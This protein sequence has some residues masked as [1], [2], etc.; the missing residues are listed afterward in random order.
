MR[1]SITTKM[2]LLVSLLV[3]FA[4]IAVGLPF[5]LSGKDILTN[6]TFKDLSRYS[7]LLAEHINRDISA[8]EEDIHF[9]QRTPPIQGIIR[10]HQAGGI[11]PVTR[12]N[13]KQWHRSLE[14]IF[15]E[16]LRAKSSYVQLMYID[17]ENGG[18]EIVRVDRINNEISLAS[19]GNT[20]LPDYIQR[21]TDLKADQLYFSK[22]E[23]NRDQGQITKPYLPVLHVATPVYNSS[24]A[25]FGIIVITQSI[26]PLLRAI[27]QNNAAEG[28]TYYATNS[29]GDYID[30]PEPAITYGFD[31]GE[32]Y[33]IQYEHPRLTE[34]FNPGNKQSKITIIDDA[35]PVP[36][37]I[38][39]KK[40][41]YDTLNPDTYIAVGSEYSYE[42]VTNTVNSAM[43]RTILF[44]LP[45]LLIAI[46][47]TFIF[48]RLLTRPILKITDAIT[49]FST[50]NGSTTDL[51]LN[52]KDEIGFLARSIE[53]MMLT[54]KQRTDELENNRATLDAIF[55][56]VNEAVITID[57]QGLIETVNTA[58]QKLFGYSEQELTGNNIS[59]LMPEPYRSDHDNYIQKYLT[60]NIP[61]IIGTG[62]E[63]IAQNRDGAIFPIELS[64]SEHTLSGHKHFT[65]V[66]RDITQRVDDQKKIIAAMI[67]AEQANTAKS[68]FLSVMNHELRTP[69]NGVLGMLSLLNDAPA[70]DEQA[71]FIK[72]AIESA[73]LLLAL[74]NDVIEYTQMDNDLNASEPM[75]FNLK[76][77]LS[78]CIELYTPKAHA[79]GL[80]LS[81]GDDPA[82]PLH[83]FVGDAPRLKKAL[84]CLIDNAIKYTPQGRISL[85]YAYTR[86]EDESYLIRIEV[87]DTGIGIADDSLTKIFD[88]FIQADSSST[89]AYGGTGLGL[90]IAKRLIDSMNGEIGVTSA[91]NTGSCFWFTLTLQTPPQPN[92]T[93]S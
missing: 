15:T 66:I 56:S 64:I 3:I 8:L 67:A 45:L 50:N 17:I 57:N 24:G 60:T 77:L 74:L 9:L 87:H 28:R 4:S 25:V 83:N 51:P 36:E 34:F 46:L 93:D 63:I 80:T 43:N 14:I 2:T 23:L 89:R 73:N 61:A 38:N 11:D 79:R 54:V 88:P 44:S 13:D 71:M 33:L 69:L 84:H 68:E 53:T 41:Y 6:E 1:P 37:V 49:G 26:Q 40:V 42:H 92:T 58:G 27:H 78:G 65:G 59:S 81:I 21:T 85:R 32:R 31:K 86:Q 30:H 22:I 39:L 7:D 82:Y 35:M 12:L 19:P 52:R 18:E 10:A 16:F 29:D 48:T 55:N 5:Y 76:Q 20:G 75:E 70:D 62:R 91:L 72:T 47:A 90:S